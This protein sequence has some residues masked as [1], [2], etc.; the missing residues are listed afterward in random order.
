M[1]SPNYTYSSSQLE[2]ILLSSTVTTAINLERFA[3]ILKENLERFANSQTFQ[4]LNHIQELTE[5]QVMELC[6][7]KNSTALKYENLKRVFQRL[8]QLK[9]EYLLKQHDTHSIRAQDSYQSELV[10]KLNFSD[11]N[12]QPQSTSP[13]QH[14]VDLPQFIIHENISFYSYKVLDFH[15][16]SSYSSRTECCHE[17]SF[18]CEVE[19]IL[20]PTQQQSTTTRTTTTTAVYMLLAYN[21]TVG[22]GGGEYLMWTQTC[23][24][25]YCLSEDISNCTALDAPLD[26]VNL[27][28]ELKNLRGSFDTKFIYPSVFK[29]DFTLSEVGS[30]DMAVEVVD[31]KT[32]A[33]L[34]IHE[35][36][37][38]ILTASLFG[39]WYD[40]DP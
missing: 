30:W 20:P 2:P 19:Y 16:G 31:N 32:K 13:F 29:Q 5:D 38:G 3:T 35:D 18:C 23:G 40:L 15:N 12:G 21:G 39:R 7:E 36:V 14:K 10:M 24:V 6:K 22:K 33:S 1:S 27:S 8:V 26:E 17:G 37:R 9:R 34:E 11:R 28:L 25:V 4:D